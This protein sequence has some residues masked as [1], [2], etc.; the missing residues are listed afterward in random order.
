ME[1]NRT[2]LT[3]HQELIKEYGNMIDTLVDRTVREFSKDL[4]EY[5]ESV[6]PL[7]VDVNNPI[8]DAELESIIL[9]LPQLIY[10]A[11][12][13]QERLGIR[14]EI[15][16][17]IREEQFVQAV[18]GKEGSV[19]LKT[20][21]AEMEIL[22]EDYTELIYSHA[23]KLLKSKVNGATEILQ[24]VKKILSKRMAESEWVMLQNG[25]KPQRTS[26]DN[27]DRF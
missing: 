22:V 15:S 2:K 16:H 5:I 26:K 13:G 1:L 18:K 21:Q 14:E 23:S 19:S 8:T 9:T 25:R 6:Q 17:S 10:W 11:S 24:S 4:D 27:R 20:K 12:T 7:L 3:Q